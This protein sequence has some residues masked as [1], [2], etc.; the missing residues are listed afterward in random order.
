MSSSDLEGGNSPDIGPTGGGSGVFVP[1]TQTFTL[2]GSN[3]QLVRTIFNAGGTDVVGPFQET[4]NGET[5]G[6]LYQQVYRLGYNTY[7]YNQAGIPQV[8]QV[9]YA[10]AGD[11]GGPEWG[12]NCISPDATKSVTPFQVNYKND[13]TNSCSVQIRHGDGPLDAIGLQYSDGTP[14][15]VVSKSHGNLS[16]L[17]FS[18]IVASGTATALF[19]AT[20]GNSILSIDETAGS[21]NTEI[22]FQKAGVNQ[23][24]FYNHS[25]T[26]ILAL[27]NSVHG[28]TLFSASPASSYASTI[29]DIFF[30]TG[31]HNGLV[32]GKGGISTSGTEGFLWIPAVA[33]VPT[34]VPDGFQASGTTAICYDTADNKLY[35]YNGGWKTVTLS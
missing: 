14:L 26:Q 19:R 20:N 3:H 21:F 29:L 6:G 17:N 30:K 7:P 15:F 8:Q 22:I 1:I 18:N 34:G 4:L 35:A 13:N 25:S 31:F 28:L 2:T 16:Y 23:W 5:Y 24:L 11:T 10:L 33:G 9:F 27:T 12:I 32:V